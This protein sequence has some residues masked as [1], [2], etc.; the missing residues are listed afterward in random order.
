MEIQINP[1]EILNEMQTQFPKETQICI[2]AVQIRKMGELLDEAT[3][4][5]EEPKF[6]V[7]QDAQVQS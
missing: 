2:Q 5:D 1:S 4:E 7:V 3:P 6:E